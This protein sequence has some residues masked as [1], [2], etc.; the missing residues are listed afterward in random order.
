MPA[1]TP[2]CDCTPCLNAEFEQGR[3]S[4]TDDSTEGSS[5]HTPGPWQMEDPLDKNPQRGP[6]GERIHKVV[7]TGFGSG[8][9]ADVSAWWTDVETARANARLIAAA[10]ELLEALLDAVAELRNAGYVCDSA[11]ALL[12]RLGAK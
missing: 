3:R 7:G 9:V 1:H 2:G 11:N 6:G 12:A 5:A 4:A 10:P 8:L